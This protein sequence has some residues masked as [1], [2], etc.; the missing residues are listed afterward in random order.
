MKTSIVLSLSRL[1]GIFPYNKKGFSLKWAIYTGCY[2]VVLL[3]L[4]IHADFG[5]LE[6]IRKNGFHP[7]PAMWLMEYSAM[8]TTIP[9]HIYRILNCKGF[10]KITSSIWD[11]QVN[12]TIG[13]I[14][15]ILRTILA[16]Y[17][18][19]Q[20]CVLI[21]IKQKISWAALSEFSIDLGIWMVATS[22]YFI[23]LQYSVLI[24]SKAK[25]LESMS[26]DIIYNYPYTVLADFQKVW[27]DVNTVND[28]YSLYLL[29]SATRGTVGLIHFSFFALQ[30]DHRGSLYYVLVVIDEF[31]W[32][33]LNIWTSM[34]F[35]KQVSDMDFLPFSDIELK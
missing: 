12:V 15:P 9:I 14:G 29:I 7:A 30:P 23:S 22:S 11:S 18:L 28:T 32:L 3:T 31:Q 34:S 17:A 8:Y 35:Q 5:F 25:L 19:I 26:F 24:N 10:A 6:L 13:A 20:S 27:S 4:A 16:I 33:F 2:Q 1:Y 21:S